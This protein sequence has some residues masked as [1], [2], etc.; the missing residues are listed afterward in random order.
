MEMDCKYCKRLEEQCILRM[1]IIPVHYSCSSLS[2]VTVIQANRLPW[3][4]HL[5]RSRDGIQM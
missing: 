4:D 2:V 1:F 3:A 5:A